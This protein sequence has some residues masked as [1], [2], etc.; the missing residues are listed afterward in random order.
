MRLAQWTPTR[1]A[2]A[3]GGLAL[4]LC[5]LACV[6]AP[7]AFAHAW[8]AALSVWLGVPLGCLA[9]LLIHALTGGGWGHAVRPTLVGGIGLLPLLAPAI[10]PVALLL[11]QAYPWARPDAHFVNGFYLNPSFAAARWVIYLAVW[12]GLGGLAL[13]R[14]RRSQSLA[15]LAAGGLIL[16]G[17]TVNFAAIDLVM[18]LDPTFNSSAFGMIWAAEAGLLELSVAILGTVLGGATSAAERDDLGQLLQGLL[19]LWAY[20][21]FMQLLIVWQSNLPHEAAWYGPRYAGA[22]GIVAGVTALVHFALPFLALVFPPIRRS[23]VGLVAVTGTLIVMAAL[24]GWWLVLPSAGRGVGWIDIGAM[25]ALAGISAGLFLRR[26]GLPARA[27]DAR[28]A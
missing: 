10:V 1:A 8:V 24:R 14:L 6:L 18:S 23:A 7:A 20:L 19:V 25:L 17:L 2:W 22:W 27:E 3:A 12:F 21:D 4:L 13:R 26:P 5:I 15:G 11:P 16:L 9:L 28:H